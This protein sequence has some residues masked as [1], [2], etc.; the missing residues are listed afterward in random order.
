MK[1]GQVKMAGRQFHFKDAL[2]VWGE[3]VCQLQREPD[4]P[5][6]SNAIA[7]YLFGKKVGYVAAESSKELAKWLDNDNWK[8]RV[9]AK[10]EVP[11]QLITAAG[12]VVRS[13]SFDPKITIYLDEPFSPEKPP[14]NFF[15]PTHSFK[16]A[17]QHDALFTDRGTLV[18]YQQIDCFGI[19]DGT[20]RAHQ[21]HQLGDPYLE[22]KKLAIYAG[23]V[24]P[25][26]MKAEIHGDLALGDEFTAKL[27]K[28]LFRSELVR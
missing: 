4:N 14:S 6:D 1:F 26:I 17:Y 25:I 5:A 8:S 12:R 24:Y 2:N 21:W 15:R 16:I 18:Y 9:S 3:H 22:V 27:M 10:L 11:R 13:V 20:M 23:C 7:V 28:C 19:W